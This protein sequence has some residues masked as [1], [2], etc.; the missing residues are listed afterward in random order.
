MVR[1][2]TAQA[3]GDPPRRKR[4]AAD[5]ALR[6][7]D[8]RL[9]PL[10]RPRLS[11]VHARC[12]CRQLFP[13]LGRRVERVSL[14]NQLAPCRP[15]SRAA[16][17]RFQSARASR[18]CASHATSSPLRRNRLRYDERVNF[19][20]TTHNLKPVYA[21]A[22]DPLPVAPAPA[23]FVSGLVPLACGAAAAGAVLRLLCCRRQ[24]EVSIGA[25]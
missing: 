4:R 16:H 19:H 14:S 21:Q 13:A 7:P 9:R 25:S 1:R 11:A 12:G 2:S 17:A 8:F 24:D 6:P 10:L 5:R 22:T 23:V 15:R 20:A 3:S 18:H